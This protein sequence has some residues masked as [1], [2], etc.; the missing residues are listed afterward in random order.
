MIKPELKE[1]IEKNI[2]RKYNELDKAH[3]VAHISYVINKSMRLSEK[4]EA[5]VDM[6]YTIAAYHD[7]G[8]LESR[9]NHEYLSGLYLYEDL[10]LHEW[11]S[12]EQLRVMKEAV[13]DHR[14]SNRN[15]PRSIYGK[16]LSQADRNLDLE[17]IIYRA[18]EFGKKNYPDFNFEQQFDRVF[19]Y[20]NNKY[21]NFWKNGSYARMNQLRE[22]ISNKDTVREIVKK[23]Y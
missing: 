6:V 19:K 4:Y 22:K 10:N 1:Y 20:I 9:K 17:M 12:D 8:M 18:V 21:G 3:N 15:E 2:I 13:E 11:F 14:A 16:I 5:N 23:Y 7:I